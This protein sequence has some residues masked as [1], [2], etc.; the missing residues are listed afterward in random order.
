M[1]EHSALSDVSDLSDTI[2]PK[3][4]QLTADHLLAGPINITITTMSRGTS[5]QPVVIG[6]AG[7]DG[8]PFKPCKS[9]RKIMIAAWGENGRTWVGRKIRLYR[10]PA[11]KL[12]KD[13]VGGIRI[14]HLSHI[15]STMVVSVLGPN[16]RKVQYI[17]EPL[18]ESPV[19][20]PVGSLDQA[21]EEELIAAI[22]AATSHDE[23]STIDSDAMA[24]CKAAN[25]RSAAKRIRDAAKAAREAMA[26]AQDAPQA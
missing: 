10:D 1:S 22:W 15:P 7:D 3:S 11:V 16:R 14:S 20:P 19:A 2:I 23:I 18:V 13:I 17:V 25:D 26:Q 21:R 5:E 8:N 12:G 24:E 6:Y 4:D 9:M